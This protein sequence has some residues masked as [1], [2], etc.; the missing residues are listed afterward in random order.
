VEAE[1]PALGAYLDARLIQT[2]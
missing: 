1:L 2:S